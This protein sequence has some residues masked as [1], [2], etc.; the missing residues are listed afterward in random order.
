[1]RRQHPPV[2][3]AAAQAELLLGGGRIDDVPSL[4]AEGS[5]RL[6]DAL[7]GIRPDLAESVRTAALAGLVRGRKYAKRD[8][9]GGAFVRAWLTSGPETE[10]SVAYL[11]A[12]AAEKLPLLRRM[13]AALL[14]TVSPAMEEG[15]RGPSFWIHVLARDMGG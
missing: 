13:P 2:E 11:R 5:R 10:P 1:M 8:L 6:L 4:A 14:V 3:E 12:D 9:N 15:D 7:R